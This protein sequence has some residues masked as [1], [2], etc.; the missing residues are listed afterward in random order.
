MFPKP[1]LSRREVIRDC[2]GLHREADQPCPPNSSCSEKHVHTCT[3]EYG[4]IKADVRGC[5]QKETEPIR[6]ELWRLMESLHTLQDA[7]PLFQRLAFETVFT[8]LGLFNI[9]LMLQSQVLVYFI[10]IFV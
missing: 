4:E 8:Q 1:L 2:K 9:F 6:L 7:I 5:E 10:C 3:S